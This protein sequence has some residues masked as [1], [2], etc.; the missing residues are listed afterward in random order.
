MTRNPQ[1]EAYLRA[2][3]EYETC[4]PEHGI[5]CEA[6]LIAVADRI[7]SMYRGKT[8]RSV[9]FSELAEITNEAYREYRRAQVR[10]Q[11]SR[12]NRTR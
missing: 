11:R 5:R 9:G 10:L 4:E 8:G 12:I 7:T 2:R 6:N 3:Y 1:F